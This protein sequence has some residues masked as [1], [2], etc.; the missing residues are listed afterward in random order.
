LKISEQYQ[1]R[2]FSHI[3]EMKNSGRPVIIF[4]AGRAGWYIMKVLEYYG[5]PIAAFSDND[6]GKQSTSYGYRVLSADGIAG[7]FINA[8]VLLGI[9]VP[10]TATAV[11]NQFQQLGLQH[12][13]NDMAAFLF[14]YFVA[15]AGRICDKKILAESIHI[16]FENYKEGAIHYGLTKDNYYVSPY[17]TSVITQ[18]CSLRCRDCAQLIPYYKAPQNFTTESIINDLK[19]YSK[20]FDVV[21]EISLHGGE[22]FMHPDIKEICKEIAAIPNII[23]I[24]F[25]TNGTIL[26]SEDT[27]RQLSSCGAD[28]HQSGGYGTLSKKQAELTEAFHR[29][30][31]YSDILF[32]SPTE[33]WTRSTQ[34]KQHFRDDAVNAA[35]YKDCVSTK[36]CCQIMNGELHR[37]ALSMHGSHQRLFPKCEDD[38]VRLH[39]PIMPDGALIA[40]IRDFLDRDQALSVCDYCD[41]DGGT[42][43][44][45]AIQLSRAGRL[46]RPDPKGEQVT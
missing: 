36:T 1:E 27:L 46:I 33:M 19:Q 40:K 30:N 24:S 29:H 39:E 5:V 43:V 7:D 3:E 41:P 17:V 35:L 44:P 15:V 13:H 37:C 11:R 31:L 8:H 2:V 32:C 26:P 16:L 23:F 22:P 21:P 4:G 34:Y 14:M 42:L 18:K 45:P 28:V 38:F 9:F 6:P 10:S 12:V 25:I 20:A